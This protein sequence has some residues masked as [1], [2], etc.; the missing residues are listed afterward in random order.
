MNKEDL[1]KSL[2][3]LQCEL[4][5]LGP[6][7]DPAKDRVNSLI[8]DL[9]QQLRDLDNPG[10]RATMRDRLATLIEEFES[11]HPAITGMLDQIMT[12]LASMGV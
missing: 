4:S 11:K 6:E 1:R 3:Q 10:H 5:A 7:A 8:D 9:Q 12:T 2:E